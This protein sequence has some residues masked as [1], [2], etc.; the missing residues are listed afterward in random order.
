[1]KLRLV[2]DLDVGLPRG[3][4]AISKVYAAGQRPTNEA[5][6]NLLWSITIAQ[7]QRL[8]IT[9]YGSF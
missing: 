6:K 3:R 4:M 9:T 7:N 5:G 1:M 2:M 8:T